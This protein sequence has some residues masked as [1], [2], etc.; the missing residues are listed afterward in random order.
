MG[1]IHHFIFKKKKRMPQGDI[2]AGQTQLGLEPSVANQL[3]Q[4]A[5][6]FARAS[7][8]SKLPKIDKIEMNP[9]LLRGCLSVQRFFQGA[10]ISSGDLIS[11]LNTRFV[12]HETTPE[13]VISICHNGF[14]PSSRRSTADGYG[15]YFG[16]TPEVSHGYCK[17]TKS[18]DSRL[19]RQK[20][21]S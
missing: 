20:W 3:Y 1:G 15:E 10:G 18:Y 7:W 5:E 2:T 16:S 9:C 13:N 6:Q 14:Q 8:S 21:G 12:F 19:D 17:G 11:N 4:S